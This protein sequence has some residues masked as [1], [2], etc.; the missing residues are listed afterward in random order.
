MKN[1]ASPA[2][3]SIWQ[4]F[5]TKCSVNLH[6]VLCMSPTGDTLRT[7]CRNFPGLINNAI[8][9]WFLPWPEQALLA[10]STSLLSE[11]VR[12]LKDLYFYI[13]TYIVY[14]SV[15]KKTLCE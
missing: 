13:Y 7:R 3:E 15:C 5:V 1:G 14:L 12:I 4:Y 10:V 2:K 8:I 11:D 6:V 9:D